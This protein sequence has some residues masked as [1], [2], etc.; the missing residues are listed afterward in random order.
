MVKKCLATAIAML[1]LGAGVFAFAEGEQSYN[2]RQNAGATDGFKCRFATKNQYREPL[3]NKNKD[4]SSNEIKVEGSTLTAGLS[5]PA[6]TAS[7]I[8]ALKSNERTTNEV[9]RLVKKKN[10]ENKRQKKEGNSS[11]NENGK[12][13]QGA[14]SAGLLAADNKSTAPNVNVN[15]TPQNDASKTAMVVVSSG[16]PGNNAS[17][18]N[19]GGSAPAAK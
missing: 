14:E 9:N 2:S 10:K 15:Q 5:T 11:D 3:D 18:A 12:G 13:R 8:E 4:S 19:A 1:L 6:D 7:L 17:A 16:A